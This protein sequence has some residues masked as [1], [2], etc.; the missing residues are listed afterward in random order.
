[1][2]RR[3][4]LPGPKQ[5]GA[6]GMNDTYDIILASSSP[7]RREL[8]DQIGVHY[9]CSPVEV[10][11]TPRRGESPEQYVVRLAA[12]KSQS[13]RQAEKTRLPALGADTAVVLAGEIMGKPQG[14]DHALAMLGRLSGRRHQ[15]MSA[16]SVRSPQQH[17]QALNVSMVLFRSIGRE[18]M[19]AYW[20][21]GEPVDKAGAYAIQGLGA[22]FVK[23]IEGSFSGVVGLPLYETAH[24]LRKA[25]VSLLRSESN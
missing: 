18:E 23:H 17:W 10:D 25:G 22:L 16:V 6:S 5:L 24:L 9:V 13:A 19:L 4:E 2:S 8:L 12:T 7:R 1:M 11:E 14:R 20:A 3:Q 21:T 15:V